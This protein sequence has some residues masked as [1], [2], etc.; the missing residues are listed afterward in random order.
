MKRISPCPPGIP[1][2]GKKQ[3]YM[4][5]HAGG[6][7]PDMSSTRFMGEDLSAFL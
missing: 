1:V 5:F 4:C 2:S 3:N 7:A 6:P